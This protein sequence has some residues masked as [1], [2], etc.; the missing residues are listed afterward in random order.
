MD[1]GYAHL[2]LQRLQLTLHLDAQLG[3]KGA[4]RFVEQDE[5][6]FDNQRPSQRHALLLAARKL[7]DAAPVVTFE[8]DHLQRALS[9]GLPLRR[10]HVAHPQ[11]KFNIA[12]NREM[13]KERK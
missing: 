13:R 12:E 10:R 5:S 11:S 7:I 3:I 4:K 1:E 9:L 8:A 2:P 6:R